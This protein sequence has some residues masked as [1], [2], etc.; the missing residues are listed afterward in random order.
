MHSYI[1]KQTPSSISGLVIITTALGIALVASVP[2]SENRLIDEKPYKVH[3]TASSFFNS[4]S[5]SI[6][7]IDGIHD[8]TE[9]LSSFYGDLANKQ[10]PLGD[11]FSKILN[12]NLWELYES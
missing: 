4:D 6:T 8:F 2:S 11:D 12:E 5:Y 10:E 9:T 7:S 3:S 1:T